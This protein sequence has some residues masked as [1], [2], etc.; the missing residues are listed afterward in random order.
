MPPGKVRREAALIA[1]AVAVLG[2]CVN[3]T[4]PPELERSDASTVMDAGVEVAADAVESGGSDLGGADAVAADLARDLADTGGMGDVAADTMADLANPDVPPPPIDMA[5]DVAAD[6]AVG[7]AA[8]TAVDVAADTA[9]DLTP[10]AAADLVDAGP[11]PPVI[12]L[13]ESS[14]IVYTPGTGGSSFAA[15]CGG[16][17]Q[18]L[19]GVSGTSGGVVG[20]NSVQGA[21]GVIEVTGAAPGYQLSTRPSATLGPYGPVR[22]TTHDGSCPANQVVVGFEGGSGSWINYLFIYCATLTVTGSAG[23]YAV[24]VGAPSRV[25]SRLGPEGGTPFAARYCPAGEIAAGILGA[26]GSAIDR[27]GVYCARPV[28]R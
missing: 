8:D 27:F 12:S 7:V 19:I 20:L 2:G 13:I 14:P 22:P 16:A 18:A 10:D 23:S 17:G 24:T 9:V 3:L 28:A 26:S 11:P 1:L 15:P 25:P 4:R 5:V 6:T 21:C